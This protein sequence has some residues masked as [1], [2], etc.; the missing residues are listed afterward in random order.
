MKNRIFR[1]FEERMRYL[2]A[3][4]EAEANPVRK[5]TRYDFVKA[6]KAY[7]MSLYE[8][9]FTAYQQSSELQFLWNTVNEL[10]RDNADFIA[11]TAQLGIGNDILDDL[12]RLV[13][14][15]RVDASIP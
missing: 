15:H 5:C 14:V 3:L 12:F 13:S 11:M 2:D 7:D 9:L 6:L 4:A 8:R 1:S 10:D